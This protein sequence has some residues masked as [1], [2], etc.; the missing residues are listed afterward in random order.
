MPSSAT[1]GAILNWKSWQ[2]SEDASC[3]EFYAPAHK[4]AMWSFSLVRIPL[5]EVKREWS[6]ERGPI[7]LQMAA[8]HFHLYEDLYGG[9]EF[10]PR[11]FMEIK[12]SEGGTEVH[13]G[14]IIYPNQVRFYQ[15]DHICPVHGGIRMSAG[16]HL[17]CISATRV[18]SCWLQSAAPPEVVLP[19]L[20]SVQND[21]W[22]LVLCNP[23]GNP[24]DGTK[25][26]LHW[27]V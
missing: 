22:T 27:M 6:K 2:G 4:S 24:M 3:L 25:E 1:T 21:L 23:D 5:A 8:Q 13:R 14:N 7:H 17:T 9:S 19:P 12:Y 11:G 20:V 10:R 16:L 18:S 26:I 15:L